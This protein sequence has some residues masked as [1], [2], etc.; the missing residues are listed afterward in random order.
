[1][2]GTDGVLIPPL[3][4]RTINPIG[5]RRGVVGD[6][7]P[8]HT[9]TPDL[10]TQ[11]GRDALRALPGVAVGEVAAP[12]TDQLLGA[13]AMLGVPLVPEA[14]ARALPPGTPARELA[15]ER[16][17]LRDVMERE[18]LS[19]RQRRL[20]LRRPGGLD[21]A[22]TTVS[23]LLV[24]RRPDQVGFALRQV[25]R[26]RGVDAEVVLHTHGFECPRHELELF[27]EA[28]DLPLTLGSSPASA[29]FGTILNEAAER[30]SGQLLQKMDD[31]D[32]YGPDFLA[33]NVL[34]HG[35][36]DAGLVGSPPEFTFVEPLWVTTRRQ[37]A[38]E[39]YTRLVAGG[40]LMVRRDLFD[41]VGGF[42]PVPSQVDR[43]LFES[44]LEAGARIYATHGHNYL[45]RR[46]P[47]G[48]TWDPG[49]PYFVA[50]SRA[51]Q[52]W[53]GFRPSRLLDPD[54][55]AVPRAPE[56]PAGQLTRRQR[57][58]ARLQ[59]RVLEKDGYRMVVPRG[60]TVE[61]S[62][63]SRLR[64]QMARSGH[65]LRLLA[66]PDGQ[67][68]RVEAVTAQHGSAQHGSDQDDATRSAF[69][70]DGVEEGLVPDHPRKR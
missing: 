10:A 65:V 56:T 63:F 47:T 61:T 13:L 11:E 9:L 62:G 55:G 59:G 66:L 54:P 2:T 17:A 49:L 8:L 35:Y 25:A 29:V 67:V 16:A 12:G 27:R 42:R 32:W 7:V 14:T 21:P 23:V 1:M 64:R 48:H 70:H 50:R 38:T 36:S 68:A 51:W 53:P 43:R 37:D 33:D 15:G 60:W 46:G 39:R 40:T 28:S 6:A 69:W 3:D 5:F 57:L 44:V 22:A 34:A 18:V 19:I 24:T 4:P 26:Q 30:A 20:A 52:Q 41:Q 58:G 45:L 31:D